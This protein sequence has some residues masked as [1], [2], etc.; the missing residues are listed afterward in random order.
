MTVQAKL[1]LKLAYEL[2]SNELADV[3]DY[4]VTAIQNYSGC[5]DPECPLFFCITDVNV[6][7]K[8][9]FPDK[10]KE[11]INVSK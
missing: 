11:K 10:K 3:M 8:K 4:I 5:F 2:N 1:T 7:L 9:V 6:E